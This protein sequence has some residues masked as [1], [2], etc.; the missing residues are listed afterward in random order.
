[1][2]LF[3]MFEPLEQL[4][5]QHSNRWMYEVG[6]VQLRI[7]LF[8]KALFLIKYADRYSFF[9]LRSFARNNY[10]VKQWSLGDFELQL[11]MKSRVV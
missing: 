11:D 4:K 9:E 5:L 1:M 3:S 8:R 10:D 6:R 2:C 7:T